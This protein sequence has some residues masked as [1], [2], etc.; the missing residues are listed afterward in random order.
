MAYDLIIRNGTIVDGTGA[1]AYRGDV[2]VAEGKIAA[3]GEVEGTYYIAMHHLPGP[4]LADV[5]RREAPMSVARAVELLE[6]L[7]KAL[8]HAHARDL[9]HRDVK[10]ANAIFDE[11]GRPVL[12]DF[13]L[14]KA[15]E[16]T[17]YVCLS[18]R[19]PGTTEQLPTLLTGT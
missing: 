7:A 18:G 15:A 10:P 5:I 17:S 13:G 3:V 4:S 1:Q 6:P 9:V 8:D 11:E 19:L 2:A 16:K 12:V 14:V